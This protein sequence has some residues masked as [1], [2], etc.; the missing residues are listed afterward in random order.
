[1]PNRRQFFALAAASAGSAAAQPAPSSDRA[2]FVD[3]LEKLA[4][5]VLSHMA[6]RTLKASMPVEGK[7]PDRPEYTHLEAIGR[8]LCGV[9]PWLE[10][11]DP[12]EAKLRGELADLARQSIDAAT[13]PRSPDFC[14][15]E[16]GSQPVVDAAFFAHAL[17]RAPRELWGAL[18][19]ATR[20]NVVAA[21]KRTRVINPGWNNWLLFAAMVEAAIEQA[22]DR[23]D[24][25]PVTTS[26][27]VHETWYK[28]DGIYGDG[29]DLH[30]DYYNSFVIQP[31]ILDVVRIFQARVAPWK[32][33]YP[34]LLARSQRYAA[35]QERLISPEGAFP[36]IGRSL[37][38]RI[39]A[40]QLLGQI[41]LMKQLPAELKPAQVRCALA[42]V[43]RRQMY[44]PGTFD[45]NGWLRI[46]FAGRQPSVGERYIST[47]SLYLSA[48]GLLPLGLPSSDPFWADPPA[49]WTAKRIWSGE[50]T[51]ADHAIRG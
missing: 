39:G 24:M 18:P 7:T 47:G 30:W 9:A 29:P 36:A 8:L 27:N 43:A 25:R 23:A 1:M 46:G 37:A 48:A 45:E 40:F 26:V 51:P 11:R 13:D 33:L 28:G 3:I 32:T 34:K 22:G 35:I 12:A 31:M 44:A 21:L 16:R 20:S 14:N 42:A 6:R 17:L 19:A 50:D 5:P 15:W 10:A 2:L 41:V 49:A 4:R 38:Y